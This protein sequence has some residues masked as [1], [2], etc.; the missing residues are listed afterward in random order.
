MIV[1]HHYLHRGRT[2]AQLAYW[3]LLDGRR[4]GVILFAYPRLSVSFHGYRPMEML[5]LARMWIEPRAQHVQVADRRGK[6]H[7]AS[8]AT[9][10]IGKSLRR[11]RADWGRKYPHLPQPLAVVSWADLQRH[12]GTVYKAANFLEVGISGGATHTAGPRRSGGQYQ[13]HADYRHF[14]RTFMYAFS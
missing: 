3:I 5:E 6:L 14:K 1:E 4:V 8:L 7:A 13:A 2:M 12:S 9:C 10:A 11:L